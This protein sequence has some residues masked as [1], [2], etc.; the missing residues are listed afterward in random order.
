M[1][2]M[3]VVDDNPADRRGISTLIDWSELGIEVA[4][5]CSNGVKALEFIKEKPVDIL[6]TDIA[7]PL[8]NGI[9]LAECLKSS[10]PGI[11]VVFMSCYS[12]FE[13]ARSAVDLSIYGYVLKPIIP[14]DLLKVIRKLLEEF[15]DET[16]K[17]R[18]KEAML[19]Q[20]K[21]MLP[22]VQEQFL[23]E[24]LLGNCYELGD[25]TIRMDYLGLG[26]VTD[27][28]V[29]VLSLTIDDY[30]VHTG[31][32]SIEDRYYISFTVKNE[33]AALCSAAMT[34]LP[35][36]FSIKDFSFIVLIKPGPFDSSN[37]D[38]MDLAVGI[39]TALLSA[40]KLSVSIGISK[41]SRDLTKAHELY[42][43]SLDAVNSKF[44]S[45]SNP[46]VRYEMIESGKYASLDQ[47]VNLEKL[48]NEIKELVVSGDDKADAGFVDRYLQIEKGMLPE[49]YVKSI[50]YSMVNMLAVAMTETGY[51]FADVFGSETA[52]WEKLGRYKTIVNVRQWLLNLF[53]ALREYLAERNSSRGSKLVDAIRQI[54]KERYHEQITVE[55]ISKAVFLS[56]SY[57]NSIVKKETGKSIFDLLLEYR[58]ETAKKLLMDPDSKVAVVSESVGYENKSYFS[59]MFKKYMGMSPSEYKA[60]FTS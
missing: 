13:Y 18:E 51:S 10:H 12:D 36:Q 56:Q 59:L 23:K 20:M 35:V 31:N 43:Q 54:I 47:A 44:Y 1:Y 27:N 24:M 37:P 2:T 49:A 3:L 21:E 39:H 17:Q 55:D 50:T 30:E 28:G 52:I 60:R 38:I 5:S 26:T 22:M 14:D 53:R 58:L 40:L 45:G 48:Y 16:K 29:Y 25:I 32:M 41:L 33:V 15:S 4:G 11:K 34:I 19:R 8:M 9:E 6:L 42:K 7:M 46:I 57:A